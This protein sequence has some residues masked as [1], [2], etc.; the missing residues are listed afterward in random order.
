MWVNNLG[1]ILIFI[2]FSAVMSPLAYAAWWSKGR[3]VF[4]GL[5]G[6]KEYRLL[7]FLVLGFSILFPSLFWFSMAYLLYRLTKLVIILSYE[8]FMWC[9]NGE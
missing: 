8:G 3:D 2:A 9:L 6:W 1:S 5:E 7:R 4:P